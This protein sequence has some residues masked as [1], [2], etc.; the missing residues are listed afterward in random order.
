M[1][2]T[3]QLFAG[4]AEALNSNHIELEARSIVTVKELIE[5]LIEQYPQHEAL[6]KSCI[7]AVNQQYAEAETA[8][9]ES[10]E[11]ALIPPVSGGEEISFF[12]ITSE[13][14]DIHTVTSKVLDPD[15]GATLT[16]VGTTREHTNGKRTVKLEYE[17]YTPMALKTMEQIRT[18]IESRWPHAR[19][20][21][22]HRI[23]TVEIGDSSVIIAVSAPHRTECYE[24][25]RYAIERL[26]Q[27]V[28]IWKK[29]L[30]EDG[31][32]WKGTSDPSWNPIERSDDINR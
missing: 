12:D 31:S 24:A 29:E 4:I 26:K 20:A 32:E 16:F 19:L 15:H 25:S 2:F 30:W 11:I 7:P 21:I 18:E 22:S 6:I 17:A 1:K 23:G 13:P 9:N 14:L 27:I 3:I 8:L 10:D 5:L 28:P